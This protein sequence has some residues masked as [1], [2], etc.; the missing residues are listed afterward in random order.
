LMN[1]RR[2]KRAGF[3]ASSLLSAI[4]G[5]ARVTAQYFVPV[6]EMPW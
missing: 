1:A 2:L 4:G 6:A 5:P 3:F